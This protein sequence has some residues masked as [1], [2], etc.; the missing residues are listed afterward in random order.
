MEPRPRL[1]RKL[2]RSLVVPGVLLATLCGLAPLSLAFEA[3]SSGDALTNTNSPDENLGRRGYLRVSASRK[4]LIR[5]DLSAIPQGMTGTDIAKA[6]LWLYARRI[7]SPGT[8]QV[9]NVTGNWTEETVT[10]NTFPPVGSVVAE[11]TIS[12]DDLKSFVPFDI[13]N[14]V[15]DWVDGVTTNDGIAL[16]RGGGNLK[17]SFDSKE[18]RRTGHEPVLQVILMG[19]SGPMG[20]IGE[21]GAV[22]PQ[23]PQGPPGVQ[24]DP[25]PQGL[26]GPQGI[27][28][29][30]GAQGDLGP[31]GPQGPQGDPGPQG[32]QGDVG[33][34]GLQGDPGPQ[35]LPGVQGDVGP[36]GP[37]GDPGLQG[38]QGVQGDVGPQGP[39][40][41]PGLQG[42][43][44]VQGDIGPQ[45]PQGDPGA[46]GLPGVQGD[47]GPQGP[48]GDPGPQGLPGA[49]GDV[50]PQGL[51]GIQ[52]DPG[53]QGLQGIQGDV[54][55]QGLQGIQG[56]PG[57]QGLPGVQGDVGPQ[58]PQGLQGDVGP[59]GPQGAQGVPGAQGPQGP[60]GDVG[61]QGPQG[62]AGSGGYGVLTGRTIGLGNGTRYGTPQ[63][64]SSANNVETDVDS[65][66][67]NG[68]CV[69]QALTVQVTTSPGAGNSRTFTLRDDAADTSLT[70][71]VSGTNTTCNSG[72]ATVAIAAGSRV[73]LKS[74]AAGAPPNTD[75]LF[76]FLCVAP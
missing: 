59:Q 64:F 52:G 40:G 35:G 9:Q 31:Q 4:S 17:A 46:Q 22:G 1:V 29:P 56:D 57:P 37:Q 51:Q 20:P 27:P 28:G 19:P 5:F 38:P 41:D 76:G 23:G 2:L 16:T 39:Q 75:A 13:T 49:Q 68:T 7:D 10:S 50:G 15:R 72:A 25:G 60:Q 42:P 14:L 12:S 63:G 30:P 48:Q 34:Q 58:G 33:P 47:V 54:G 55:P 36:Q 71:T 69:A 67:P 62:P 74:V 61:P 6:T 26:Q 53:P 3:L 73:S 45:G 18:N 8:M 66:I 21:T 44:G 11:A 65:I 32:V 43:P 70:C 24:G